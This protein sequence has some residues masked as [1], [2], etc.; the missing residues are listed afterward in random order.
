[1]QQCSAFDQSTCQLPGRLKCCAGYVKAEAGIKR[2]THLMILHSTLRSDLMACKS[3]GVMFAH[4]QSH[5]G[6]ADRTTR[7]ICASVMRCMN[8]DDNK[9]IVSWSSWS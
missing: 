5:W 1:M 2:C 7:H 8:S 3:A 9:S 4:C 6:T